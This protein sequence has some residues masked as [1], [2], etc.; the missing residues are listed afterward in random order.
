MPWGF[1]SF[2]RKSTKETNDKKKGDSSKSPKA[3][4][5]STSSSA[6][7]VTKASGRARA[8]S[9]P[10]NLEQTINALDSPDSAKSLPAIPTK[11]PLSTGSR[12]FGSE[13]NYT[14]GKSQRPQLSPSELAIQKRDLR[15]AAIAARKAQEEHDNKLRLATARRID[16]SV[17]PASDEFQTQLFS[18]RHQLDKPSSTVNKLL[19]N[20]FSPEDRDLLK[21]ADPERNPV[22]AEL[23]AK[24][25]EAYQRLITGEVKGWQKPATKGRKSKKAANEKGWAK[26]ADLAFK[27]TCLYFGLPVEPM[28]WEQSETKK[29]W[30]RKQSEAMAPQEPGYG[31]GYEDVEDEWGTVVRKQREDPIKFLNR[32]GKRYFEKDVVREPDPVLEAYNT[33]PQFPEAFN[34]LDPEKDYL[35]RGALEELGLPHKFDFYQSIGLRG[36]GDFDDEDEEDVVVDEAMDVDEPM[37]LIPSPSNA[38]V[39]LRGGGPLADMGGVFKDIDKAK[40]RLSKEAFYAFAGTEDHTDVLKTRLEGERAG[41]EDLWIPLYGYQGIVWFHIGKLNTFVDA[42][43]RLLGF[44][45]RAG[46]S[47]KLYLFDRNKEYKT[48]AQKE[49]FQRNNRNTLDVACKGLG[50]YSNDH[51][52]WNWAIGHLGS[53][54]EDSNGSPMAHQKVLFVAGPGDPI[55]YQW[56]PTAEHKVAKLILEWDGMADMNRPDV[57]YVRMPIAG[58]ATDADIHTNQYGAW[59]AQACRVLCA[60]R[61]PNRPGYPLVPDAYIGLGDADHEGFATYGGLTFDSNQW[62]SILAAY[63]DAPGEP[64]VLRASTSETP[65][66]NTDRWHLFIPGVSF[67]Y[68]DDVAILHS[69]FQNTKALSTKI[70]DLLETGLGIDQVQDLAHV[71]VHIPGESFLDNHEPSNIQISV[72]EKGK[73]DKAGVQKLVELLGHWYNWLYEKPG[74]AP[75]ETGLDMFPQ[76]VTLQPVYRQYALVADG[77]AE[78]TAV[79]WTPLDMTLEEFREFLVNELWQPGKFAVDYDPASSRVRLNQNQLPGAP[80]LVVTPLTTE[81]DWE[82]I[83]DMIVWPDLVVQVYDDVDDVFG[84]ESVQPFGYRDIYQT[85]S[86]VLYSSLSKKDS[87]VHENSLRYGRDYQLWA[88]DVPWSN[89]ELRTLQPSD[90]QPLPT[91][92]ASASQ[93]SRAAQRAVEGQPVV[94]VP[95]FAQNLAPPRQTQTGVFT[96]S[97]K[98]DLNAM[99]SSEKGRFLREFSYANPLTVA[100]TKDLSVHQNPI[101]QVLDLKFDNTPRLANGVLTPNET[102]ILQ[103][104][105]FEMRSVALERV[106]K[107]HFKGCDA[108]FP[109]NSNLWSRHMREAHTA[110]K[111]N[112]CGDQLFQH[113]TVAQRFQHFATKHANILGDLQTRRP[114][115]ASAANGDHPNPF[116]L[117]RELTWGFCCRCG[118]DHSVLASKVDRFHHDLVCYPGASHHEEHPWSACAVCGERVNYQDATT[119]KAHIHPEVQR[120]VGWRPDFCP[121]CAL[122]MRKLDVADREKHMH[123]CRGHCI[124]AKVTDERAR[125]SFNARFCPWCGIEMET[126]LKSKDDPNSKEVDLAAAHKHIES[127]SAKPSEDDNRV[128]GPLHPVSHTAYYYGI[129][130]GAKTARVDMPPGIVPLKQWLDAVDAAMAGEHRT[131]LKTVRR[132]KVATKPSA[133]TAATKKVTRFADVYDMD[134]I[135]SDLSILSEE[136]EMEAKAA[137]RAGKTPPKR[138][139]ADSTADDPTYKPTSNLVES[140]ESLEFVSD[141]DVEEEEDDATRPPAAKKAKTVPAAEPARVPAERPRKVSFKPTNKGGKKKLAPFQSEDPSYKPSK[142]HSDESELSDADAAADPMDISLWPQQVE[143]VKFDDPQDYE[144]EEKSLPPPP[145][146]TKGKAKASATKTSTTPTTPAQP[147]KP[148]KTQ[149]MTAAAQKAAAAK[150]IEEGK[151]SV[152]EKIILRAPP[153]ILPTVHGIREPNS[154]ATPSSSEVEEESEEEAPTKGR[155]RPKAAAKKA[156]PVKTAARG[157]V[158]T[159][160]RAKVAEADEEDAVSSPT[161][162]D[163][164]ADSDDEGPPTNAPAIKVMKARVVNIIRPPESPVSTRPGVV[165][166][167]MM[168]TRGDSSG[169]FSTNSNASSSSSPYKKRSR[170]RS[171]P[172]KVS[173]SPNLKLFGKGTS[174]DPLQVGDGGESDLSYHSRSAHL[175]HLKARLHNL[176]ANPPRPPQRIDYENPQLVEAREQRMLRDA[177]TGADPNEPAPAGSPWAALQKFI[178]EKQRED[179]EY[180]ALRMRMYR[181]ALAEEKKELQEAI[182]AEERAIS[183]AAM[184]ARQRERRAMRS[185]PISSNSPYSRQ[186]HE[187]AERD[188]EVVEAE[189]EKVKQLQLDARRRLKEK[190]KNRKP[191]EYRDAEEEATMKGILKQIEEMERRE[192]I[193]AVEKAEEEEMKR[194]LAK[195]RELQRMGTNGPTLVGWRGYADDDEEEEEEQEEYG[196]EERS[197]KKHKGKGKERAGGLPA[198]ARVTEEDL[199]ALAMDYPGAI[200]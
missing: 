70:H 105:Y 127:C 23:Q 164:D 140:D 196:Y 110:E 104:K 179:D 35:N 3:K 126:K 141:D 92:G 190:Y 195:V 50:D 136:E 165:N 138:K 114:V 145:P 170:G 193:E 133:T 157:G 71:E 41:V 38:L 197:S 187:H 63:R 33:L 18:F 91:P 108:S 54:G 1:P 185:G 134:E 137:R 89:G 40:S 17:T 156:A 132:P 12:L 39:S 57:A 79:E 30:E 198:P 149:T 42:V 199:E 123:F 143:V 21:P 66:G 178:D 72:D 24:N 180:F 95:G 131:P 172:P 19:K 82:R 60:G 174:P 118:R 67:R 9:T 59:M 148:A 158:T 51:I 11:R 15:K 69:E 113:W 99:D 112:F 183:R 26:E 86:A 45:N 96:A 98:L 6:N 5:V 169:N 168:H 109:Y 47:Y 93:Q 36:G 124:D 2:L 68:S 111:C 10:G 146:K 144:E 103:Q 84:D 87:I 167:K 125:S 139:R 25:S 182:A 76:F 44:G 7:R 52:A 186:Q 49:A 29:W 48:R 85:S 94:N 81:Y 28:G 159:R 175:A 135:G 122:E 8:H 119:L 161:A 62:Y 46:A 150:A 78:Q 192:A 64:I 128:F 22:L 152:G 102:R 97:K 55:P 115:D 73:L 162:P 56:E 13:P 130:R 176:E 61:I 194:N 20:S 106:E 188:V 116:Q 160:G 65:T 129:P 43:D 120:G 177:W 74:V 58:E 80:S 34:Q 154:D 155:G 83:R 163:Q 53:L 147:P 100:M 121:H 31:P 189:F 4:A 181:Q 75:A 184:E 200:V 27:L 151:G 101:D 37:E 77:D 88:E 173:L 166:A 90:T 191:G 117:Q 14:F 171:R 32:Y 107:C 142:D 153:K 16:P